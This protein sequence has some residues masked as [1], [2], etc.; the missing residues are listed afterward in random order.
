MDRLPRPALLNL[1]TPHRRQHA[2]IPFPKIHSHGHELSE[3]ITGRDLSHYTWRIRL[4]PL[5][6]QQWPAHNRLHTHPR[7]TNGL[8][9]VPRHIHLV[10][11]GQSHLGESF[12]DVVGYVRVVGTPTGHVEFRDGLVPGSESIVMFADG[13][14]GDAGQSRDDIFRAAAE[15]FDAVD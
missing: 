11:P 1:Q 5:R 15:G 2:L 14:R 7:K 12:L 3:V 10:Q 13:L 6:N 9:C 4:H 8:L